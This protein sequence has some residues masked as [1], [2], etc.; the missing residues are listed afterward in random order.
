MRSRSLLLV[1]PR[2][3][4]WVAAE[5]PP[6]G[7]GDLLIETRAGA[8]SIGSELPRY[9]GVARAPAPAAY[10]VMTGYESVGLVRVAGARVR[11]FHVGDRVVATYGH[12]THAVIPESRA[13]LAP[14]EVSDE[15]A[16]LTI[17]TGDVA[18]GIHKLGAAARG[19]VLVSGGGA[20]GLLALVLLRWFGAAR[21]DVAEPLASRRDLAL[22]LGADRALT[23]S[24]VLA[25]GAGAP[26]YDTGVECSNT[27]AGFMALQAAI[28]PHGRVC[29]L[30]DGNI[31]ALPLAPAFHERQLT[32]VGSS[33]CP[34]YH[35]HARWYFAALRASNPGLER[36][37]DL[38]VPAATLPST[39]EALASGQ[40]RAI[41]ALVAYGGGAGPALDDGAGNPRP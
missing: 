15:L 20:I 35:A 39:F 40:R 14:A 2:R 8:V 24:Q 18:T 3:L 5:L 29:V 41:K 13:I 4:E 37:F 16:L 30:A 10:P 22:A 21:V 34:D 25:A 32:I 33:D 11:R 9:R 17:L 31:E 28:K 23:P 12:L 26:P 6:L 38:R 1:A 27:A 36:L 19:E 7:A